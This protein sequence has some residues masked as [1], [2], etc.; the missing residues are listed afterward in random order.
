MIR[1]RLTTIVRTGRER[2][3]L[4]AALALLVVVLAAG[5][6]FL[7]ANA[8]TDRQVVNGVVQDESGRKVLYW[9]DPMVPNERYPRPGKSSMSMDLVPKYV[10]EAGEGGVNV[11]PAVMQNLGIRLAR[12]EVRDIA[13]VVRAVGR[14]DFDQR[15]IREVQTLTPGFV[16]NLT[17]RAEG[18]P[19]GA[20]RVIAR[21]YSPELLAAQNEYKALL[22]SRGPAAAS[23][24]Q[25]ARSRLLLLGA[26]SS[27]VARLERG[28]A[29]QR[30]Y[31]VV[32]PTSGVVTAIGAR[33]GSQVGLGESIVTIQGLSRVLVIAEVPEASLSN[34]RVGQPAEISFPAYPDD[35][36]RGVVDYI[37]PSLNAQSRTAQVR[38]TLA[39]PGGKLKSGMFANVT[40]EGAGGMAVVVPSEALID[41]GRRQLVIVKRDGSFVPQE[42]RT[43]RDY[44]EWT[45]I[46]AGLRP[47]EQVVASG[48]FLIDS[49]ASLSGFLSRL[50]ST[51]APAPRLVTSRGIVTSIDGESRLV[52]IRHGTIPELGWPAMEMTFQLRQPGMLRGLRR[53][54]RVEFAVNA[55]PQGNRYVIE[56]IAPGA[57]T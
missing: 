12:V 53:G 33:P 27:L 45:Q 15:L 11:S 35:V 40:L 8:G 48:Q 28:G 18:E 24:R 23:V 17:V 31:P 10:D 14:V 46:V 34:V 54:L 50:E 36:R 49:E 19:I 57:G 21:V 13:P 30:T 5:L 52:T 6:Y 37:F 55:Q 26:P 3:A 25:A 29:P 2:P 43:G 1:E 4:I 9:Y 22:T 7:A 16:E 51:R 39:N 38:I 47:G 41:T 44:D 42:V 32:T 56:R 20:G